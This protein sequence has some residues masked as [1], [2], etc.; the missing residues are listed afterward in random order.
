MAWLDLHSAVAQ[1]GNADAVLGEG[2]LVD[3]GPEGL[4]AGGAEERMPL[5]A[6]QLLMQR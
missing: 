6:I 3:P 2:L 5:R 1:Q 4:A